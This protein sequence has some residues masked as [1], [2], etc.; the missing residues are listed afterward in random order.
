MEH[1][2]HPQTPGSSPGVPQ[3]EQSPGAPQEHQ[4]HRQTPRSFLGAPPG[5]SQEHPR[6]TQ[7]HPN[8]FKLNGPNL[9]KA[10]KMEPKWAIAPRGTLFLV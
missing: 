3:L 8:P 4:E 10:S 9:F 5:A 6:S 7:E 1:Q 2:M